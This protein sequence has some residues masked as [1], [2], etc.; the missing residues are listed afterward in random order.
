MTRIRLKPGFLMLILATRI[1][2]SQEPPSAF[3]DY[4][5]A[6]SPDGSQI[7]FSSDRSGS[8]DVFVIDREGTNL[9]QLTHAP[10]NEYLAVWA[11]DGSKIALCSDRD[12]NE[13]IYVMDADGLNATN[14][15]HHPALDRNPCW[16]PDGKQ[17]LFMTARDGD[18]EQDP[19][20]NWELYVM[21]AD[22]LNPVRLTHT[23][24]YELNTGQAYSPDG[25]EIVFCSTMTKPFVRGKHPYDD[26]DLY[27]MQADGSN[28]RRLTST[29]GQDSYPYWSPNG[30]LIS[31]AHV[32]FQ[33]PN[34]AGGGQ[35]YEIFT[36]HPDGSNIA[37]ITF[38]P[39][40]DFEGWWSPDSTKMVLSSSRKPPMAIYEM[41]ADGSGKK[42]LT[43]PP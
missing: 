38:D 35:N 27:I 21:D 5:P 25:T 39:G 12:G 42:R 31:Y 18:W 33:A 26:F 8:R 41:N 9:R 4:S 37:R 17:I 15:T 28:I 20:G 29:A 19:E 23:I 1:C 11:P 22:G 32:D 10:S 36:I 30:K 7:V 14:I 13:E 24:G 43:N 40:Y 3:D 6:Y 34:E 2:Q 16:T